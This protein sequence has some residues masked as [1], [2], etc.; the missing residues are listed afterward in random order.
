MPDYYTILIPRN[1][2]YVPC[3]SLLKQLSD[4]EIAGCATKLETEENLQF[5]SAM[6]NFENVSCPHCKVD[7]MEW[8]GEAMSNAYLPDD[9]GFGTLDITTPCCGIT[10]S[11][12]DLDYYFDQGFYKVQLT[13]EPLTESIVDEDAI[14]TVLQ[15]M[16]GE[17][18]RKIQVR[19]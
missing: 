13:I 9:Q 2:H 19:L 10:T 14:I 18:W 5:A 1:P 16:T 6:Q 11:L 7:A 15:K 12:N 17:S 3:T 4:L 8:W